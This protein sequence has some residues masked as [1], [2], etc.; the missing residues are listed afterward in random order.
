MPRASHSF[1]VRPTRRGFPKAHPRVPTIISAG[2]VVAL[3]V[4]LVVAGLFL[5]SELIDPV[6]IE[7]GADPETLFLSG[8]VIMLT[9]GFGV[10]LT[11]MLRRYLSAG[12]GPKEPPLAV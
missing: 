6:T 11:F 1:R 9:I 5:S 2:V 3:I 7:E 4:A 10:L 12:H 8:T